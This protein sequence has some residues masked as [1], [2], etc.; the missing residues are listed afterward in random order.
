MVKIGFCKIYPLFYK[1]TTFQPI[2]KMSFSLSQIIKF[3]FFDPIITEFTIA[4]FTLD[5][6]ISII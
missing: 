4:K 3:L 2:A 1:K 6:D 5:I